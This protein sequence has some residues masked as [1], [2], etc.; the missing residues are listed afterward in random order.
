MDDDDDTTKSM[1]MLLLLLLLRDDDH[2]AAATSTMM[3]MMMMMM[4][5]MTVVSL[6]MMGM[7][8]QEAKAD[9][10]VFLTQVIKAQAL[11]QGKD[12][13]A[14]MEV[15]CI[16]CIYTYIHTLLMYSSSWIGHR[17]LKRSFRKAM[18]IMMTKKK[19]KKVMISIM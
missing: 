17:L 10:D 6:S 4:M 13:A 18:M 19:K 16:T 15:T 9:S 5:M 7:Y 8:V 1:M 12:D 2:D 3:I 11:A 14:M